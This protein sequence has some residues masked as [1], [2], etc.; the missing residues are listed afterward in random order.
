MQDQSGMLEQLEA[1]GAKLQAIEP[2]PYSQSQFIG[3]LLQQVRE[4]QAA[5]LSGDALR[6]PLQTRYLAWTSAAP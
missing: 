3:W 5:G 6:E 2:C 4:L 1:L